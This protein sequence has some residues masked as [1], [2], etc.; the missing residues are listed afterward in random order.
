MEV[1]PPD[2]T[3]NISEPT[4]PPFS[5][6]RPPRSTVLY[7][8]N[9]L[10]AGW[11]I[12]IYVAVLVALLFLVGLELRWLTPHLPPSMRGTRGSGFHPAVA[13]L[14]EASALIAV[15]LATAGM[16]RLE[17]RFTADYGLAGFDRVRQFLIGLVCGFAFLACWL[18][19]EV[20]ASAAPVQP[21]TTARPA[22]QRR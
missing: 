5:P 14:S 4:P 6:A 19:D 3:T 22:P 16:A 15:L 10:R 11:S 13:I 8:P 2:P 18:G 9:G 17:H 1:L 20:S 12:V 21:E 7:G